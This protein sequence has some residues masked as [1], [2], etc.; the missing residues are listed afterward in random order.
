MFGA[1]LPAQV[2]QQDSAVGRYCHNHRTLT[3]RKLMRCVCVCV[4]L[5]AGNKM[6]QTVFPLTLPADGHLNTHR[7]IKC[8]THEATAV[9][10]WSVWVGIPPPTALHT[11]ILLS[12]F[13]CEDRKS[14][15]L[16]GEP[17]TLSFP[18][19]LTTTV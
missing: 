12:F 7:Y 10:V 4:S 19:R 6:K 18:S 16:P 9:C 11:H 13:L 1:D 3:S 14:A 2:N 17:G 8:D 5:P 15:E